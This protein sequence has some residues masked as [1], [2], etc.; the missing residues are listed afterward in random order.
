MSEVETALRRL[1]CVDRAEVV[2]REEDGK[3]KLI[4]FVVP[5]EPA[6][7]GLPQLL[8]RHLATSLPPFMIPS[9][10]VLLDSIPSLPGG[11]VDG[12]ALLR[13]LGS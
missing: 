4:A 9:R 5:N 11:K 1:N 7:D 13:L 8:R 2:F 3:A 12:A 6:S 10:I